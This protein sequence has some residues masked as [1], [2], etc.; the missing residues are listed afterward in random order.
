VRDRAEGA[1]RRVPGTS[2]TIRVRSIVGRFLEHSRIFWFASDPLEG[3][4][5]I[6]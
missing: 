5:F 6:G 1:L 2:E 4:F 3:E